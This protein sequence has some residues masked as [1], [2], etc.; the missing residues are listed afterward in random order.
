[1]NRFRRIDELSEVRAPLVHRIKAHVV[2]YDTLAAS[3]ELPVT[4]PHR[5]LIIKPGVVRSQDVRLELATM[6]NDDGFV[7]S[8]LIRAGFGGLLA[9]GGRDKLKLLNLDQR[10][11]VP[12]ETRRIHNRSKPEVFDLPGS[13]NGF[14]SL[15]HRAFA[16]VGILEVLPEGVWRRSRTVLEQAIECLQADKGREHRTVWPHLNLFTV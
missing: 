8:V 6:R 12:C 10:A 4:R 13:T 9:V 14:Q 1:M 5:R 16:R 15:S 7:F 2:G 3:D 11:V